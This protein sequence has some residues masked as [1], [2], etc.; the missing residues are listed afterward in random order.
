MG[1]RS[2]KIVALLLAACLA[3]PSNPVRAEGN[4]PNEGQAEGQAEITVP[5]PEFFWDFE[6]DVGENRSLAS[7]GTVA[8]ASAT[9]QGTAETLEGAIGI[10]ENTYSKNAN[11]VLDL[12]GG[13]K[14]SSYVDLPSDLYSG[15]SAETGLTW[16]FWMKPD[17][18]IGNYT[19]VFSS[20]NN[21]REQEFAYTPY[22]SDKAWN[23]AFQ[24]RQYFLV[25]KNEP[26]KNKWNYIT[27]VVSKDGVKLYTNGDETESTLKSGNATNLQNRLQNFSSYTSN[28]LGKMMDPAWG[29]PDC[30]VQLDDVALYRTALSSEQVAELARGYGLKAQIPA[31]EGDFSA[32][33]YEKNAGASPITVT[34]SVDDG[35]TLSY[36]W[37]RGR[38]ENMERKV[39]IA[40]ATEAS[41]TPP[42]DTVGTVYYQCVVTNTSQKAVSEDKTASKASAATA[43]T[44]TGDVTVPEPYYE[45]TFDKS[46]ENNQVENEG[47]KTGVFATIQ[48]SKGDLGVVDDETRGNKVLNLPGGS[49]NGAT[50]GRLALPEN[51]FADVTDAGF[52]FSFWI[53]ID[54]NAGQYSRIFS[55]T[56][57]GQNSDNGGGNWDAPEFSFVV[58][59]N[60]AGDMA[61]GKSGYN[62]AVILPDKTTMKTVWQEQLAKGRWQH[63]TISVSPHYYDVYLDGRS[64]GI[65]YDRSKNE[66]AVLAKLFENNAAILKQ[67]KDCAIGSSVYKTD[68]DLKAKM[69]EFRFYNTALTPEQAKEA[70]DSYAVRDSVLQ[71]LREKVEEAEGKSVSFFTR[72]SYEALQKP[73]QAGKEGLENPVTEA[74]VINLTN[75]LSKALGELAYYSG[76]TAE[77]TFSNAQLQAETAEAQGFVDRDVLIGESKEKVSAAVTK[78]QEALK[79]EKVPASQ[80]DVDEA[81][82]A[83]RAAMDGKEYQAQ[84]PA[85]DA[86]PEEVTYGKDA[87]A[88]ALQV[89]A[90]VSDG[91]NLTYQW[92]RNRTNSKDWAIAIEGATQASYTPPTS[93]PGSVYYY[94]VVTNTNASAAE[95]HQT[96]EACS[97]FS[98][99]T[100]NGKA[101]APQPYYEFTFDKAVAENK[102]ENEGS[103]AGAVAEISGNGDGLEIL[104]DEMRGNKVLN[105]PGGGLG[106]GAL[107]LP[108]DMFADVTYDGF[109]F[110]F[111]INLDAEA[112]QYSRIFTATTVGLNSENGSGGF[113]APEFTFVA[114]KEG[115]AD[116]GQGGS[117]YNTSIFLPDRASQAKL[118]WGKQFARSEWQH[119]TISVSPVSYDVYLDGQPVEISFDRANNRDAILAKLFENQG[120]LLKTFT[121]NAIGRSVYS[122]D[123]DLKAKMDEFRFYNT[124]LTAEQ[125]K[126]AYDSYAVPESVIASLQQKVEEAKGKSI[127]FYTRE[128]Y[129][130]LKKAI[131][132]GEAGVANP[133]TEKNVNRLINSL[134]TAISALVFYEG[135]SESTAFSKAQ[136]EAETG[137][138]QE[139]LAMDVLSEESKNSIQA[140]VTGAGQAMA[141]AGET[142]EGQAKIDA[143]LLKLREAMDAK[144]CHAQKPAITA[145]PQ[146]AV[147]EYEQEAQ[148]LTVEAEVGDGGTLSYQ[149]YENDSE[150][151]EGATILPEATGSTY[152]PP[153]SQSGTKYYYCKVTNTNENAAEPKTAVTDSRMAKITVNAEK[154]KHAETPKITVQPQDAFYLK[155]QAAQELTVAASAADGGVI[156]YQ[157]YKNSVDST[158]GAEAI[159][160][161]TEASYQPSTALVQTV[162]Y[163]CL[164][165]NRNEE[166]TVE[167]TASLASSRAVVGVCERAEIPQP[168]YEFTFD[169]EI[170]DN[171]VENEGSKTGASASIAGDGE[172]L[173]VVS[174]PQRGNQVLSLP[175]GTQNGKKEGRLEL[176]KDMFADV[177]DA[178]FAF[179]F[180][181]NIDAKASQYSRIFSG[182]V[183]GQNSDAGGGSWNAPEFSFVAGDE[184]AT[185]LGEGQS[186]YHT[187]VVLPDKAQQLKLVWGE[188]MAKGRWQ[189]VTVSVSPTSYDVYLDGQKV[190]IRYD[191]NNNL[192]AVLGALFAENA[193]VL[194]QYQDCAIG[195]SVYQTD[196]DLKARV[197]EFRFYNNALTWQQ[198]LTAYDN[199]RVPEEDV[200]NLRAK[201]AEAKEKSISFYTRDSFEA[202]QLAIGEGENG[203]KNP[204]TKENVE[205]LTKALAEAIQG[206][207]FYPGISESAVF[208]DAQLKAE[209]EE[210]QGYVDRGVLTGE[211]AESVPTALASAKQALADAEQTKEGQKQIDEALAGLRKAMDAK[212]YSAQK[213]EITKEPE[214]ATYAK[215]AEAKALS[216][217]AKISDSGTLAYQ[218]YQSDSAGME[219]ASRIEGA[220]GASY[221][222]STEEIG[223]KYYLCAV[224]NTNADATDAKLSVTNS[225]WAAITVKYQAA[226][227]PAITAQ[228]EDAAYAKGQAPKA[229][230]VTA[231]VSDGGTLTY[232][233]YKNS[234]DST[235]GAAPIEGADQPSYEPPTGEAGTAYYYCV[236]TNTNPQAIDSQPAEQASRIAKVTVEETGPKE[237]AKPVISRQPVGAVYGKMQAAEP[238]TVEARSVDGGELTYQW[239]QNSTDST[240]GSKAIEGAVQASYKPSTDVAGTSYYYCIVTNTNTYATEKQTAEQASQVVA[241][242]VEDKVFL[243]A[244]YYEFTFDKE[245]IGNQVEN[246][247]SKASAYADII[248][249]GEGL[250][251]VEDMARGSKVLNLP[252]GTVNGKAEGRLSLPEGI[253]ADVT[254]AGFTFSFWINI[255]EAASQYS[256]IFSGTVNGQNSSN[257]NNGRWDAPEFSFVAGSGSEAAGD[258]A[259]GKAGYHSAIVLPD[260]TQMKLVWERQFSKGQWQHVTISVSPTA[261]DVYLDGQKVGIK[262]DRNS[263]QAAV[264]A[265]LFE[266]DRAI[267]KQYKDCAIGSSVYSTDKDLKA[268]V[269]EFRFYNTA[270]TAE[271]AKEAYDSYEVPKDVVAGLREKVSQAKEKSMSHYTRA[272]YEALQKAIQEGEAG[273]ENPVSEQNVARLIGRLDEA[274]NGLEYYEGV[275]EGAVFSNAQLKAEAEEAQGYVDRN[276]LTGESAESIPAALQA[277]KQ[278]IES[279]E[280][281]KE[282]QAQI[283][284]ALAGL[285]KAMD[286]KTYSAQKPEIT[287]EPEAATYAKDAEA[288]ALSVEAKISDSGTLAYQWYQSDSAGMEGASR[289]EGATGASYLPSTEEIGTKY[290]LCAVSNTNADATDAKLSVTN[291]QWAAITV[292]Y[293]AAQKPMM[294]AQP[295][296]AAYAKGQTPKALAVTAKVSDGGTLTYQW[297]KN[298]TDSTEG[299]APV[300]G[301]DQP[302]YEPSTDAAGISYYYCI[303]T[304]T[305]PQAIDSQPAEQASRIAKVTVEEEEPKPTDAAKPEITAQPEDASYEKG[306][307]ASLLKVEASVSDGGTL[308]YQWY[309]NSANSTE[310]GKAIEGA[311]QASYKPSTDVA[312][313]TYYYCIVTNT[314]EDATGS[315]TAEQASRIAKVTV[316]EEEPK[317]T[318]AAKPE[319]TAQPEDASYE[320]GE[321]ASLLKVEASVSDGGTLSYQWYEN[322]ANSTE[323]GKAIEGAAQASYQPST[324]VVG[325]TYYYCIV[326]N[327]NKAA[328]GSQTAFLPSRAAAVT[329]REKKPDEPQKIDAAVPTI[330]SQPKP[331]TYARKQIPELL[332]I[333]AG[334]NDRGRLTYQ[335]YQNEVNSTEGAKP[336]PDAIYPACTPN[337]ASGG[338][339][340]YY[341]LV[342]NTNMAATGAKT[343]SVASQ[344]V[345]INVKKSSNK[346]SGVPSSLKKAYGDDS[347]T[348]RAK[349]HGTIRYTSSDSKVVKVGKTSGNVLIKGC[350]KAKITITAAGNRNYD[351]AS[352]TITVTVTPKKQAIKALKPAKKKA[353]SIEWRKDAKAS[354][355]QIQ[356]AANREFSG[357]KNIFVKKASVSSKT[358]KGL[359]AGK[360]YYV[361][362]R[363]YKTNGSSKI[364]GSWSKAKA[365]K[366]RK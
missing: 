104:E 162:Y 141:E 53:N 135:V 202:L 194:K 75:N 182:T 347:F 188:Q 28:A 249:D 218:W 88:T 197:D 143:A 149:W 363:A 238:L 338:V 235:E 139:L 52:A 129:E 147:Y 64:I 150:S 349:G 199:Y 268:R 12:K 113:N 322:S 30:A 83:L 198:A 43:V 308:S 344:I 26:E 17:A 317:P 269:D 216:V 340:Y 225:Q 7:S 278:A 124:A 273:I 45:F 301:A 2:K 127:S 69:D 58:G 358:V 123:Q 295:E 222:P 39:L 302:S 228:P 306:E 59:S 174:D 121:N 109:A 122:T 116:L 18:N 320:K 102:I 335:W 34:A 260:N 151:T 132:E 49:T 289:I 336:I 110:S 208:S 36:Q 207:A 24:N 232:Q 9:M 20:S 68:K 354:G 353:I 65:K 195:S 231:E 79:L 309:E 274:C 329:I 146:D 310:G 264:L 157:W 247:G 316:E 204:V 11:K 134:N 193:S 210:A 277:A 285:R 42:T 221:L 87:V 241:I 237:A 81:L 183:N 326:T 226:Q 328:T 61:E 155:G 115:A 57:N 37:Y 38:T 92:Y 229:L 327:T 76:V 144:V 307:E 219:G 361:R 300:E 13:N 304:N 333:T 296:D 56:V 154:P 21:Q 71:A 156:S 67:Y 177:T 158:E 251:V 248:G 189:H 346:V 86:L 196:K 138:A 51:M 294:T 72:A 22:A 352:K 259:E 280:Q 334:G 164:V 223:T 31:V 111:W 261:Y 257:G 303:V 365:V 190:G 89:K 97:S 70:Y 125:A 348:L 299:A 25:Y 185:D 173:G 96:A 14:G 318:D 321:E 254:D 118:V 201:V 252:G 93:Q 46:V 4:A 176:P 15:V 32:K 314:K 227:K 345:A 315:K 205:R 245:I 281:T 161:A 152:V 242:T 343:A 325:T 99:V 114:G 246:E 312:G 137:K 272:T 339:T 355:Y 10:G 172:G 341:C 84:T 283:D 168:Y 192:S 191:R 47:S 8:G 73:I 60:T 40:G 331:A 3:V 313:T 298:S 91:G 167:Q 178:G 236:V 117:G 287:K 279:A 262:Y 181:I 271:Q 364:N 239:Y 163:Y 126:A 78:A 90:T 200:E 169:G 48:G 5:S 112:G 359:K 351:S 250:G 187:S 217:E 319:I 1:K 108:D 256:R 29:D 33:T 27:I 82:V 206:L 243:P 224:S 305:N 360:R 142:A 19:R 62:T 133:V 131:R 41:Y 98:K 140:A 128:S 54:A 186:G 275:L 266:N 282:G 94:C 265:K 270:L 80:A 276:V 311:A 286:A 293:Q 230:A 95:G 153:T 220:T 179:S 35:G 362:I 85:L 103:K 240:E 263:N 159:Q 284:E 203:V 267:L 100:V 342:T 184:A 77:T 255:D 175:G 253:F 233:W 244:P 107:L 6:G 330:F 66:E 105:L 63:V 297:Y 288:K 148:A 23:V 324:D 160:G 170:T 323:G 180:W 50:E 171:Q 337:T 258:L 120:T 145:E 214:A 215:D 55:G 101:E 350:G 166:A 130:N 332:T 292:K 119:V 291:S 357:A 16:S 213:P 212:T 74:N 211:S 44:V 356:Y 106:K 366:V 165:T 234:A 290:Y 136:L 209:A